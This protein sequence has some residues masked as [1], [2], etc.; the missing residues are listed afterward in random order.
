MVIFIIIQWG[1]S[2]HSSYINSAEAKKNMI[3]SVI[4]YI[5]R[6]FLLSKRTRRWLVS[7]KVDLIPKENS[8][9]SVIFSSS[10][11]T[12]LKL[13]FFKISII[14]SLVTRVYSS[15]SSSLWS[16]WKVI[17]FWPGETIYCFRDKIGWMMMICV[18]TS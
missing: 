14:V 2:T 5:G 1:A 18:C 12:T 3:V 8:K 6:D 10:A 15:I 9:L 17:K 4:Q 16:L 7:T 13:I 11:Q